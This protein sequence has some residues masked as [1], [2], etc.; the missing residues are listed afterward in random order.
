M[1]IDDDDGFCAGRMSKTDL[2]ASIRSPTFVV[3]GRDDAD[4]KGAASWGS[5]TDAGLRGR[6]NLLIRI[7]S[8]A[9]VDWPQS[10]TE[11]VSGML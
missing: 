3:E 10:L 2:M 9:Q 1:A 5:S 11:K 4:T 6:G 8:R 7:A